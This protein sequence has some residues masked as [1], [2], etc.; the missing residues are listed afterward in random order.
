V[1]GESSLLAFDLQYLRILLDMPQDPLAYLIKEIEERPYKPEGHL[2]APDIRPQEVKSKY[3]DLRDE[4]VKRS[5]L[6]EIFTLCSRVGKEAGVVRKSEMVVMLSANPAVLL[7]RFPLHVNEL[8]QVVQ[9]ADCEREG[10]LNLEE[11]L[12]PALQTLSL[13]G[14]R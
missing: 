2:S 8:K 13:P 4:N 14:G 10:I 5:L 11:F 9:R 6:Q 7:Q 12:T 1:T 3:M